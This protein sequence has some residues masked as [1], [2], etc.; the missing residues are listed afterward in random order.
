MSSLLSL[1]QTVGGVLGIV[2]AA[3]LLSDRLFRNRPYANFMLQKPSA[4]GD[5]PGAAYLRVSNT[6]NVTVLVT[7]PSRVGKALTLSKRGSTLEVVKSV[8]AQENDEPF[9][10]LLRPGEEVDLHVGFAP[11]ADIARGPVN[12]SFRIFWQPAQRAHLFPAL[13]KF[14]LF[15]LPLHV[16]VRRDEILELRK[17]VLSRA[18]ILYGEGD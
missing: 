5:D 10:M 13:G 14:P 7:I 11:K 4:R 12:L 6:A 18:E 16:T 15:G 9:V 2:S 17:A 8:L 3:I 1:V